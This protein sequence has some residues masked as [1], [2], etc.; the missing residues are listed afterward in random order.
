M[1][2]AIASTLALS[3]C[4]DSG[5][6]NTS[7]AGALTD[8]GSFSESPGVFPLFSPAEGALPIPNDLILQS[9]DEE[10]GTVADGSYDLAD[11]QPPVTTALNELSGAS[12]IAPID[13]PFNGILD[14]ESVIG[15][16][17][18]DLPNQ[19][20]FLV[21]LTYASGEP[22]QGLS[23]PSSTEDTTYSEPPIPANA[24][25]GTDQP[26]YA[27]E[28]IELDGAS[29]IRI[30]PLQ[31]LDPKTRY[32]VA[33]TNAVKDINGD[34][35]IPSPGIAGY[36]SLSKSTT[37]LSESLKDLR[38]VQSLI[39]NLWEP[40][41]LAYINNV[42]A[43]TGPLRGVSPA[44][45]VVDSD[46][47]TPGANNLAMTY[48]FTTSDDAMVLTYMADPVQWASDLIESQ[49]AIGT[50][51]SIVTSDSEANFGTVAAAI[52]TAKGT[53][54]PS[55]FSPLLAGCGTGDFACAGQTVVLGLE[56]GG[57]PGVPAGDY[58]P[59][60]AQRNVVID[61]ASITDAR[62]VSALIAPV[63]APTDALG[64]NPISVAQGTIELPYYLDGSASDGAGIVTGSWQA[65]DGLATII[66]GLLPS[67]LPQ[68]NPADS[69]VVNGIFPFPKEKATQ[70]AKLLAIYP[71]VNGGSMKTVIFQ[72][73]IT[74][75]RSAALA[76]GSS[77]VAAAKLQGQEVAVLA[78][79]Q[80]LHGIG[81]ISAAEKAA[82]AE[83]LLVLGGIIAADDSND[84]TSSDEADQATID[85]VI[86][87]Q[88]SAG[89]VQGVDAVTNSGAPGATACI[90]L[91][92]NGLEASTL[93]I[94]STA[95]D[96]DPIV[97]DVLGGPAS[98]SL[99]AALVAERTV[100]NGASQIPGLTTGSDSER[101]F[102]FT[103]DASLQPTPMDFDGAA[104]ENGSGALFINLNNFLNSRD[105]LRQGSVDLLN[106]RASLG[107][108]DLTG[109]GATLDTTN[110]YF[111]GHSLGTVNGLPFV[112]VTENT[113][114][115][116]D[117][118]TGVNLLTPGGG[119]TRLIEN[120]P[121][122]APD[123]VGGLAAQ[124]IF[125]D[126]GSY[127]IFLNVLQAATD[128]ADSI[129]FATGL[130]TPTLYSVIVGDTVIPN[131]VTEVVDLLPELPGES[132]IAPLSGTEPLIRLAG[133]DANVVTGTTPSPLTQAVVRYIEGNGNHGTP[134]YPLTGTDEE[135]AVF[136]EMIQQAVSIVLSN[137]TA[138]QPNDTA[139]DLLQ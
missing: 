56:S 40:T 107:G 50:A 92:T 26:S 68:A 117:D 21:E 15:P 119:V 47:T 81:G 132:S 115:P 44:V 30:N 14:T 126:S 74:S 102:G 71:T 121:A 88:F 8:P 103:A 49:V 25:V 123:I 125:Q 98:A 112:R 133:A 41:T 120:S 93:T 84:G 67:P 64:F 87:A 38:P 70:T 63:L 66:S 130:T 101:H 2:A 82:L 76:F 96:A 124:G 17:D 13:I 31:P 5:E 62:A 37:Q 91:A 42:D 34:A 16:E 94:L 11:T 134:V 52:A 138:V 135:T 95:C 85:A 97:T 22:V 79:D 19:N 28:V 69:T 99:G 46:T 114:S 43:G 109:A 116:A 23:L 108:I 12:T 10:K 73:G 57:I 39:T 61:P 131:E 53:W 118:L 45:P 4:L 35:I 60:A 127:Q 6:P 128:S 77:L 106:L 89:V 36:G 58:F 139:G 1:S 136:G 110:V 100:A 3:G 20:V 86:A 105:N 27:I 129:N 18:G 90:D 72:H 137:G 32:V 80:P 104:E 24:G 54:D 33:I 7:N 83:Q 75:D 113:T 29:T 51:D 78:I 122:F 65:D 59:D 111:I 48:S 9:T 55:S